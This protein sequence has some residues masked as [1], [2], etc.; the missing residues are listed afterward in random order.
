MPAPLITITLNPA[1]DL[2]AE[3]AHVTPGP[4]LRTGPVLAEPGGGGVNVARAV[5]AL[6]GQ[7]RALAC[8]GGPAGARLAALMDGV[9]GL[10]LVALPAP[11]ETRESLSV[12]ETATGAQ[13]RFVLPGPDFGPGDAEPLIGALV[14]QVPAGALV[15]LSGS[16]PQ[17][18]PD[19]LPARLARAL[20]AGARLIVDTSGPALRRLIERPEPGAAPA[21]LRMDAAEAQAQSR[22]PLAGP[23]DSAALAAGW[24]ARGVADCV[25][26]ARGAE[27]SVLVTADTAL[28]CAPPV[29]AVVSTVGAGDSF[30]AGLALALARGEG[31]AAAL[32]LGTA[33]AAAAVM[34][35]GT[36]LCRAADVA[37]LRPLCRLVPLDPA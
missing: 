8:L 36:A 29:V 1:L 3:V 7:V 25:I 37:R 13:Y 35:P 21:I 4:K 2:S 24:V 23:G 11:G 10:D 33:A 34:T 18:L 16:Q 19:D 9:P 6:G 31:G 30:V 22:R 5:V 28:L 32:T 14:A 17:G 15:V 20:P 12:T 27:G 26:L